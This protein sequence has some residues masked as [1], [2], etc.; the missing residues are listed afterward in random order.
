MLILLPALAFAENYD[1]VRK[2][3]K[4]NRQMIARFQSEQAELLAVSGSSL[5]AAESKKLDDLQ[6]KIKGL[7]SDASE[8][9]AM[10]PPEEQAGEYLSFLMTDE[11]TKPKKDLATFELSQKTRPFHEK[12]LELVAD[13]KYSE[14][15]QT[16]EDIVLQDPSDDQAYLLMG[17]CYLITGDYEKAENAFQNS[18]HIDP[19][20]FHTIAPFYE[21]SVLQNPDDENYANLGYAY[22]V[23][24]DFTKAK[25]A[26][27][28]ALQINPANKK[29]MNGMRLLEAHNL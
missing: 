18:V 6:Y 10:L 11:A 22:M 15:A 1:R 26:F 9:L 28:D 8:L 14:A 29:A 16:Y 24:S 23:L 19:D 2:D 12:A 20:N 17:H 5:S 4:M 25:K 3:L 7:K 13:Q 27:W 21:N